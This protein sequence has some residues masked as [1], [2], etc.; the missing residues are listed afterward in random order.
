MPCSSAGAGAPA[1]RLCGSRGAL[2][3]SRQ[4]DPVPRRGWSPWVAGTGA[5]ATAR[6]WAAPAQVVVVGCHQP[7]ATGAVVF[8]L[9]A[10]S[11][12]AGTEASG[13]RSCNRDFK[14]KKYFF[15]IFCLFLGN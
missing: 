5:G 11:G 7:P 14:F 8:L 12:A 15:H 4:P 6:P 1:Q 13:S 2:G 9:L 3:L 10:P